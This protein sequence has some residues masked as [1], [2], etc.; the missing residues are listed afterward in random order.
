M[1]KRSTHPRGLQVALGH[2]PIVFRGGTTAE[3]LQVRRQG[4]GGSD[5][6]ALL[7]LHPHLTPLGLWLEKTA[8]TPPDP[9][10]PSFRAEMG[11][12]MEP[13]LRDLLATALGVSIRT[14][15]YVCRSRRY[16]VC[17]ATPDGWIQGRSELVEF[18]TIHPQAWAPYAE[19]GLPPHWMAQAQHY[20][21][22]IGWQRI[23]F[24]ILVG[25]DE[26]VVRPVDADPHFILDWLPYATSWWETYVQGGRMPPPDGSEDTARRLATRWQDTTPDVLD[27]PPE[28]EPHLAAYAQETATIQAAESRRNAAAAAVKALL[29]PHEVGVVGDWRVSWR[30]TRHRRI[31]DWN[32]VPPDLIEVAESRTF[33]V[34]PPKRIKMAAGDGGGQEV[35]YGE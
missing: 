22:V 33:R 13:I 12:R 20:L 3:W 24:G 9:A 25:L 11:H 29:G 26:F 32:R 15:R 27:L 18:K 31:T 1:R 34:H 2:A 35:A 8:S 5:A 16:P 30:R 23:W 7:G 19:G 28:A 6:A 17:Q 21:G 10:P 14:P 4:I